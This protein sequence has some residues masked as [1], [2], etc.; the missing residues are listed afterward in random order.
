MNEARSTK[1]DLEMHVNEFKGTKT[2]NEFQHDNFQKD[3]KRLSQSLEQL[4]IMHDG[5]LEQIDFELGRKILYD[6]I[7]QNFKTLNDILT[8][9][10][11]QL[12]DTKEAVRNLISYQKHFHPI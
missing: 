12:E 6:D 11:K 7:K 3:L 4:R 2:N 8:I 1:K 5:K 10:F 9:K